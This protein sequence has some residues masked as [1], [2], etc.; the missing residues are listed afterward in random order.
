MIIT[1]DPNSGLKHHDVSASNGTGSDD[2]IKFRSSMVL[3]NVSKKYAFEQTPNLSHPAI[4]GMTENGRQLMISMMHHD[5]A[6]RLS[7]TEAL[8]G[9]GAHLAALEDAGME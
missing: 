1:T 5:P 4:S 9:I 8:A 7:A 2:K 3:D 6:L